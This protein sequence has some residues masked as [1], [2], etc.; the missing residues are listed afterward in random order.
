M[1]LYN[2]CFDK[3]KTMFTE[4]IE[5]SALAYRSQAVLKRVGHSQQR[6]KNQS[7]FVSPA[8]K[9]RSRSY[10]PFYSKAVV[11]EGPKGKPNLCRNT[12]DNQGK[13][14][15]HNLVFQGGCSVNTPN[16]PKK[17]SIRLRIYTICWN[18]ADNKTILHA[19][20]VQNLCDSLL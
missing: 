12:Q 19:Q 20:Q 11:A 10:R 7:S 16:V 5:L 8:N 15:D 18:F 13:I 9:L 4:P 14:L 1:F 2:H 3:K 6:P 17:N